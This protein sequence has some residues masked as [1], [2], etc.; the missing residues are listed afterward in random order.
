MT[1]RT[2]MGVVTVV[3]VVTANVATLILGPDLSFMRG[4][5]GTVLAIFAVWLLV[6]AWHLIEAERLDS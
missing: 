1:R 5:I 2:R 3:G 6:W 4:W